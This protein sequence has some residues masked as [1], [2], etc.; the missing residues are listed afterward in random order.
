MNSSYFRLKTIFYPELYQLK[1]TTKDAYIISNR[2]VKINGSQPPFSETIS[3]KTQQCLMTAAT[4]KP[5]S[6]A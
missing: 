1:I 6:R 5:K 2:Y 4:Q 3:P